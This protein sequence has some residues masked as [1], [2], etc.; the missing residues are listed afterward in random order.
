MKKTGF[1]VIPLAWYVKR[2][3]YDSAVGS[4]I[5]P[6]PQSYE[7]NWKIVSIQPDFI[8]GCVSKNANYV[9]KQCTVHVYIREHSFLFKAVHMWL[10][11]LSTSIP[12]FLSSDALMM[13]RVIT[14]GSWSRPCKMSI[15]VFNMPRHHKMATYSMLHYKGPGNLSFCFKASV[16]ELL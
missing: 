2:E 12:H 10:E 14:M 15:F 6:L 9:Y 16:C 3:S 4:C 8:F 13:L 5:Y 1:T 7:L 11:K